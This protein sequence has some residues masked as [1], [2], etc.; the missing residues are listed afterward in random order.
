MSK[1]DRTIRKMAE[2]LGDPAGTE[3]ETL[4]YI[5][6]ELQISVDEVEDTLTEG[7]TE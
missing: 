7:A 6:M 3:F 2:I 4:E 1:I 5:A